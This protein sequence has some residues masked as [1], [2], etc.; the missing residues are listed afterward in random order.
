MTPLGQ[1]GTL[2]CAGVLE[3]V[4][5]LRRLATS[6]GRK[7]YSFLLGKPNPTKLGNF[8]EVRTTEEETTGKKREPA[9]QEERLSAHTPQR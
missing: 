7:S 1:V 3:V 5:C 8:P 4:A 6:A 9:L 2:G